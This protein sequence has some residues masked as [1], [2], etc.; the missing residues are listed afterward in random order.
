MLEIINA[1]N[2]MALKKTKMPCIKMINAIDYSCIEFYM[3]KI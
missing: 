2:A 3:I 1:Y